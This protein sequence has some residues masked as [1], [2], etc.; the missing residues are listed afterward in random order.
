MTTTACI[1]LL[2]NGAFNLVV[3]P[4]FYRRVARDPRARDDAGR[5]TAFLTVH[6]VIVIVALTL[7]AVSLLAGVLGLLGLW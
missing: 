1:L 5:P 6:L 4:T 3:W 7:A 2:L